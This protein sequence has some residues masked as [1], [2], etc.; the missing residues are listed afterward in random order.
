M[1]LFNFSLDRSIK[2]IVLFS[3]CY[4]LYLQYDHSPEKKNVWSL[5]EE[6]EVRVLQFPAYGR[7][8]YQSI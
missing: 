5:C 7:K 8:W 3:A 1:I 4:T 6:T 2:R